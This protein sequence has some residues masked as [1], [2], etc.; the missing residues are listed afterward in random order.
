ML[1]QLQNYSK[2]PNFHFFFSFTFLWSLQHL[3]CI[4]IDCK[5]FMYHTFGGVNITL[6]FVK[7]VLDFVIYCS[8][9]LSLYGNVDPLPTKLV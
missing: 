4:I 5:L 1:S 9:I 7:P 3:T 6:S 2:R 8:N